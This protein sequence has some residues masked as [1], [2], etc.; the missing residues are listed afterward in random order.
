M[1]I[2]IR[3]GDA[4]DVDAAVDVF[5]RSNSARRG[6][7]WPHR[8]ASVARVR[9]K[10][11]NSDSWLLLAIDGGEPV[12]MA[13]AEASRVRAGGCFLSYL[14]VAPERWGEGIGG[15][16]LDAVLAEA[17]RRR[18]SYIHLWTADYNPRSHR[19]YRSRGFA[20]TGRVDDDDCEWAREL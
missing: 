14:F 16:I 18:H 9:G 4:A 17:K 20:P 3:P 8:P 2:R 12:A 6:G 7:V 11:R 13:S 19:L 1:S 5:E 10:L 15:L